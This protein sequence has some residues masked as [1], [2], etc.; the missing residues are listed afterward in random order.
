MMEQ[1]NADTL[2]ILT[3]KVQSLA[4]IVSRIDN[5]LERLPNVERDH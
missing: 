4:E 2:A 3:R 1:S 5:A